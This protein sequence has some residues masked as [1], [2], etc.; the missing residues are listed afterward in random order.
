MASFA[1][2]YPRAY[3]V[4][5]LMAARGIFAAGAL[6]SKAR[7]GPDGLARQTTRDIDRALGFHDFVHLYLP[8]RGARFEDLPILRAQLASA[9]RAAVPHAAVVMDTT[10]LRDEDC[11]L[12]NWNIAVGRPGVEGVCKGGNWAR[13]TRPSRVLEVWD[14]FRATKPSLE[15]ARGF[16]AGPRVPIIPGT[17]VREHWP[18]MKRH[19]IPELL[20]RSRVELGVA[21]RIHVFSDADAESLHVLDPPPSVVV[22]KSPFDGYPTNGDPLEV[23]TRR[24]L[25]AFL[26]GRGPVP[27]IDFD[28][29]RS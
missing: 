16:W 17:E 19:G 27:A 26:A 24:A 29:R 21:T 9:R 7:F 6:L 15:R 22:E 23:C 1:H 11:T 10:A 25:D 13:G 20:L 12:C 5:P 8:R 3:H 18:L 28:G 2:E 4:F 14:A